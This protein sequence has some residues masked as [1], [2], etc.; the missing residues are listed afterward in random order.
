M[1]ENHQIAFDRFIEK[2][3]LR[4]LVSFSE[5]TRAIQNPYHNPAHCRWVAGMAL[6]IFRGL[7]GHCGGGMKD[8][9]IAVVIAGLLHDYDHMGGAHRSDSENIEL[10]VKGLNEV[11]KIIVKR[12]GEDIA[13]EA[14][15]LIRVTEF[16]FTHEPTTPGEKAIRDA[17]VLY[18]FSRDGAR[19]I[20]EDL[21][22]EMS[23]K[24]GR[25]ISYAEM[26]K[27]QASFYEAVKFHTNYSRYLVAQLKDDV[28]VKMREYLPSGI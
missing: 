1:I 25:D 11:R 24:L 13:T 22:E 7:T 28:L 2:K 18:S 9:A 15:K 6:V 8:P 19:A 20:M 23:L 17:D 16:P 3:N 27:G 21:R 4:W 12:H 10:A 14:E 26:Y 5:D